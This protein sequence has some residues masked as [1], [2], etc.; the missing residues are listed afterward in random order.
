MPLLVSRRSFAI[1]VLGVAAAPGVALAQGAYP[2]KPVRIIVPFGPGGLADITTRVTGEKLGELIGQQ[3]VVLNQPGANGVTAAKAALAAPADGYTLC[4]LT[5]GTAIATALAN[6]PAFDPI[7]E[8]VPV[9]SLGFFDFQFLTAGGSPYPTLEAFIAAAKA[10]P[11]KLNIGT[12][13]VGSSQ[14]LSALLFKRLAGID[15]TIVPF[16]TSPEVLTATIRGDVQVAV[17]GFA[18]AKGLLADKQI[19]A[20]ASTGSKRSMSLPDVPT[21]KEAG[22]AGFEVDSWN[23]VF[24]PAGTPPAAIKLLNQRIVAALSDPAVKARIADLGIEARGGP[25]EEIGKRL[26]ED[27]AKWSEVID[28]AGI[29]RQ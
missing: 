2:D 9:S 26:A 4:L 23:A 8:F 21:V 27:I 18:S 1:G 20:L 16:R 15:V 5:N 6:T 13:N 12:I 10:A 19:R 29:V 17:E 22:V 24:A 11:G 25:P 3:I 28:K 14:N 7:K